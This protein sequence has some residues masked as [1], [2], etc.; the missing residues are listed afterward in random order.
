[1]VKV[2]VRLYATLKK[3]SDETAPDAS[4]IIE[5]D[6]KASLGNLYDKLEIPREEIKTA[7]V[8][9]KWEAESYRLKDGDR[10]GIFPPIG[11]G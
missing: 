4:R 1:M 9:G 2:E 11:G 3:Y 8:N 6:G 10:I 7:F 5:M